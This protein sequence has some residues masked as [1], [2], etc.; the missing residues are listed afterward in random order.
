MSV[1]IAKKRT[2]GQSLQEKDS[3]IPEEAHIVEEEEYSIFHVGSGRVRPLYATVTV[4]GNPLSLEEVDTGASVSIT[5]LE[6]FKTIQNGE[7]PLQ[8]EEP[9]VKLQTYTGESIRTCG[10]ANV[11]VTHNGQT[12]SLPL[13]V[14]E[15]KGPTLLRRNWLEALR[16]DWRAIFSV[17]SSH[18]LQ[19]V[20]EEL[21]MPSKMSWENCKESKRRSM[22]NFR[23]SGSVAACWLGPPRPPPP[24]LSEVK[25]R[26]VPFAIREKVEK[27]LD[28]LQAL[29][30]I[31][32]VRFSDWAAPIVPVLK[33]DGGVRIYGDYK[34]TINH[35][36]RLEKYPIPR[37]EEL[38]TSLAGGK[39]F[40]KLDLSHAYLQ[41]PLDEAS[42]RLVTIN[43]HKGL[44][45]Y[46]RLPLGIVS[47]PSIFQRVM[48]NLLQGIPRVC[49]YLDDI[50]VTGSTEEE[51]LSNLAQVLTRLG[52]AGTRL[53]REKCAFMLDRVSYLGHVISCEGLRTGD[54]KVKAIVD[55]PDPRDLSELRSFLGMVN[56]YGKFLP[57][58]ATTLSPLYHLYRSQAM[59]LHP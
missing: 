26:P 13:I 4:N 54:L 40:S 8:L 39:T 16:L 33:S 29:G 44:F 45:E 30:V 52:T 51:H 3:S 58:L 43:T 56:Y 14:T 12:L 9:S 24:G 5:S 36:A 32:P 50:L 37:I 23:F 21:P 35:A 10:S 22:F 55:A 15:G 53:K 2:F 31:Q 59:Q 6:T 19:S 28:R 18:T 42:R 7:S 46:R 27:E 1:I 38:F 34:V 57:N 41:I 48:E 17:G 20:L 49:V 25:F 47:A 11:Q